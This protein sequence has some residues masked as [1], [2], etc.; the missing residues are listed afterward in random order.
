MMCDESVL[1]LVKQLC[2]SIYN[3]TAS[4]K[5]ATLNQQFLRRTT[6]LAFEILLNKS[7][8]PVTLPVVD[9]FTPLDELQF[10]RFE[11]NI[12]A[13]T[14]TDQKR[15]K[16]FDQC[17][18]KI[19]TDENLL[20]SMREVL[21]LL[22]SLKGSVPARERIDCDS[23]GLENFFQSAIDD[24]KPYRILSTEMMRLP[25][26]LSSIFDLKSSDI[27]NPYIRPGEV[28][29]TNKYQFLQLLSPNLQF[30][31]N[32]LRSKHYQES[33]GTENIFSSL[34]TKK[35]VM[36]TGSRLQ[37]LL[38][39]HEKHQIPIPNIFYNVLQIENEKPIFIKSL[40]WDHFGKPMDN[41]QQERPFGADCPSAFL[42]M[43]AVQAIKKSDKFDVEIIQTSQLIADIKLLLVGSPSDT[44]H[45]NEEL[46]SF[47]MEPN[48]T[49]ENVD[50]TT[51]LASVQG[52][53]ECGTCYARLQILCSTDTDHFN[54]KFDGF[55]F[56]VSFL[57]YSRQL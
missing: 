54:M 46:L 30:Q 20:N 9:T 36:Q 25:S 53:L 4:C 23:I 18:D 22:I 16:R 3:E 27:S 44:F 49:V 17:I 51:M 15:I 40:S 39:Q 45:Y 31:E 35:P 42:N 38:R 55:V 56:Q 8:H 52:F 48:V 57:S 5:N 19:E 11:M 50:P 21:I 6:S 32:S 26:S 37:N 10:R 29:N 2:V 41:T 24:Y 14:H 34:V 1:E 33:H 13:K 28:H 47:S 43:L 12:S 7:D